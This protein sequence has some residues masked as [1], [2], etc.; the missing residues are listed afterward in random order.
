MKNLKLLIIVLVLAVLAVPAFADGGGIGGGISAK[1]AALLASGGTALLG[2]VLY[3][4][5][6]KY[7]KPWIHATQERLDRFNE[8]ARITERIARE[9]KTL[10]PNT[11]ADD[12][13]YDLLMKV[14][15]GCGLDISTPKKK[16]KAEAIAKRELITQ[17]Q[18]LEE[19]EKLHRT[20]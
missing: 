13:T 14:I 7:A 20:A 18:Y 16:A 8:I 6:R 19:R 5:A 12:I 15:N 9:A 4:L 1:L 17:L 10:F 3:L 11:T 2:V